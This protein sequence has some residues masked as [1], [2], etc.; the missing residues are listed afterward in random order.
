MISLLLNELTTARCTRSYLKNNTHCCC[1]CSNK[2]ETLK[3]SLGQKKILFAFYLILSFLHI[4]LQINQTSFQ[5]HHYVTVLVRSFTQI[6]DFPISNVSDW[7]PPRPIQFLMKSVFSA[8]CFKSEWYHQ[9]QGSCCWKTNS[10]NPHSSWGFYKIISGSVT[11]VPGFKKS[12][13]PTWSKISPDTAPVEPVV[14]IQSC[15][16]RHNENVVFSSS[17]KTCSA[18]FLKNKMGKNL[19]KKRKKNLFR[20]QVQIIKCAMISSLLVSESWSYQMYVSPRVGC[21]KISFPWWDVIKLC[22]VWTWATW[23]VLVWQKN[24]RQEL[25][26]HQIQEFNQQLFLVFSFYSETQTHQ[27][28]NLEESE[29]RTQR[30]AGCEQQFPFGEEW[31]TAT[32]M[33]V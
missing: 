6:S 24:V 12:N 2:N 26:S 5:A 18:H 10:H 29:L 28:G 9:Q 20:L 25:A 33:T 13:H 4:M 27:P 17:P 22:V 1:V 14:L 19:K 16:D 31:C 21:W 32:V 30:Q 8:R 3:A 15:T 7:D 11:D 23:Q